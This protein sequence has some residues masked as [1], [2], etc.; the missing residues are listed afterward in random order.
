MNDLQN[1]IT[2]NE[3]VWL[4]FKR[5]FHTNT[6][7]L[8]HD[9]LCL[10]NAQYEGDRFIVFG[11]ANDKSIFGVENDPNR[12]TNSDIHDFLRQVRLNKIP[13]VE[14]TFHQINEHEIGFLK[15]T[16]SPDKPYFITKDFQK[17]KFIVRNGVIY[18]RL[19]DTNIPSNDSAPEDHIERMWRERI[20]YK[21]IKSLSFE[22]NFPVKLEDTMEHVLEVLGEPDGTGWRIAH[23]YSEGIEISYDQ[24]YDFVDGVSI[25]HLP[26]GTAF[27]GTLFGIKLGDSFAKVK[28]SVGNPSY[29]G[30]CYQKS[31]VAVWEIDDKLLF[32]MIW[33]N[34]NHDDSIPFQ[35][36]GT[37]RTISY[38][39]KKSFIG[40]NAL[41][42]RAMEQIGR[43]EIP[44]DFEREDITITGIDL[45][46]PLFQ[47]EYEL[48]G[49]RPALMGGAEVLVGFTESK[50]V[51]AFWIYPLQWQ[52]PVIRAIYNLR[53]DNL[54]SGSKEVDKILKQIKDDN[55]KSIQK[56]I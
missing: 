47:K 18:T 20:E 42:A 51:I 49:A 5:E 7:K 41:V 40:Y 4:D 54:D 2:E 24:H 1:I 21:N 16:N 11:V 29:W 17:D 14:L 26:S 36:L 27:E 10:S 39:N 53:G 46:S 50:E 30:L 43:G 12:K 9:I 13:Q 35:Q 44:N 15:I 3:S 38:C 56:I 55:D 48:L 25:Y 45:N 32:V 37:V 52:Y 19:S 8:L 6:A 34:K 31:S 23:Y 33:S 28:D 22:E